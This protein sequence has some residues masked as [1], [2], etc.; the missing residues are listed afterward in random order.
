VCADSADFK[1]TASLVWRLRARGYISYEEYLASD[2]W[3]KIKQKFYA[4]KYASRK[5]D[6]HCCAGADCQRTDQPLHLHHASY[7]NLH[8]EKL[9]Q[10]CLVCKE[11]H[12]KIHEADRIYDDL[13]YATATVVKRGRFLPDG[14]PPKL[15]THLFWAAVGVICIVLGCGLGVA[16]IRAVFFGGS[17]EFLLPWPTA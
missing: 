8:N 11:C 15:G 5:G 4:S 17:L 7:E 6:K 3:K 9:W 14:K 2:H 13:W 12:D 16:I 10:L 1:G